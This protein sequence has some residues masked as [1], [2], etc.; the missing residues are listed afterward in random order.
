MC[1][2]HRRPDDIEFRE[3]PVGGGL[4][5][6]P[7]PDPLLGV[8]GR[9][10]RRQVIESEPRV[11]LEEGID[12]IP[13]VP[14]G[15][16]DVKPN[17]VAV[18]PPVEMPKRLEEARPVAPRHPDHP[19][20]TE[21]RCHPAAEVEP[22]VVL[23]GRGDPAALAPL[24]PAPTQ[25]RMERE[26]GLIREGDGLGRAE[27]L[28]FFLAG[29]GTPAPRRSAPEGSRSWRASAGSPTGGARAGPGAL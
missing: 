4:G 12:V 5:P 7:A 22:G 1:L 24:R 13:L 26:A 17:R 29:A 27:R 21:E 19:T 23:T 14:A 10:V 20:P 3:P 11:R 15:A 6:N 18:E 25:A 16:I 9:L 28:E 2:V 8:Q